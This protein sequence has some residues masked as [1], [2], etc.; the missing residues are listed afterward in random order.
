MKR[1]FYQFRL[2]WPAVLGK[3]DRNTVVDLLSTARGS[4][5]T[6]STLNM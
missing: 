2:L 5:D 4:L 6:P 1:I 3:G